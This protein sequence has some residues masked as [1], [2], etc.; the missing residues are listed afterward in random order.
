M[1]N[2]F[3]GLVAVFHGWNFLAIV[4]GTLGGLVVGSV[5]GLTSTMAMA[6]LAPLT[7]G[8]EAIPAICMLMGIYIGGIAGGS[9]AAVSLNIPGTPASA[10]TCIDGFYLCKQGEGQK[11]LVVSLGASAFG[12]IFSGIVLVTM[13]PMIASI[14]LKFGAPEYFALGI[15]GLAIIISVSGEFL[16][17]GIISALLGFMLSVVGIDAISGYSRF[18]LETTHLSGGFSY[19]AV[20][21][22]L[23]GLAETFDV[24]GTTRLTAQVQ[25]LS[26]KSRVSLR[27]WLRLLPT[28]IR[29]SCI[30]TVVGAL[31]GAGA[32][33]A[34]WASYDTATRLAGK[35]DKF[36]KG[37]L[38]GI[39]ASEAANNADVGGALI[40]MTTFGIPGDGQTAM[41]IGF[42]MIHGLDPGPMLM[43]KSPDLV[44]SMFAAVPVAS[45]AMLL[46]GLV[47]S[48][49]IIRLVNQPMEVIYPC[50]IMFCIVGTFAISNSLFDVYVM[51]AMGVVGYFMRRYGFPVPPL[52]LALILAPMIETNLRRGLLTY[53]NDITM[54]FQR[55]IFLGIISLG[56][57]LIGSTMWFRKKKIPEVPEI[58]ASNS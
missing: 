23:Y 14:G 10:A 24:I 5:P 20:L 6:I 18:T 41:L 48:K 12:T 8:F 40:P 43:Q 25:T 39:A 7:F 36:G 29:S 56:A 49:P 1:H 9:I 58:E 21:I 3:D 16:L 17:N 55:P 45:V 53:D 22:G 42:L 44:W 37:E 33:I 28:M 27:E 52:M 57:V 35:G 4:L 19:I 51:I 47:L 32:D 34:S 54:F 2:I 11:A 38:K 15:L 26:S 50:I 46:L 31:P 13:A 30:G